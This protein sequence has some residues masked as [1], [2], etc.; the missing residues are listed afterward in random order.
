M[1]L[2]FKIFIA[3]I[4]KYPL[5][6]IL[7]SLAMIAASC[8]V[9]WV[10]SGYDAMMSQFDELP[11]KPL[12]IYDL[13]VFP[14]RGSVPDFFIRKLKAD[15]AVKAVDTFLQVRVNIVKDSG[16]NK[17]NEN[18]GN[19]FA[20]K[21]PL[22]H[23][24]PPLGPTLVGTTAL[25]G[26]Y[27][28]MEGRWIR[29]DALVSEGVLTDSARGR[30]LKVDVG[31][32]VA[33]IS[34]AG[35]FRVKIVGI[36]TTPPSIPRP[37]PDI[38]AGKG[39][40]PK[41]GTQGPD[42]GSNKGY[43][44]RTGGGGPPGRSGVPVNALY[45]S[46]NLAEKVN[47][48][49]MGVSY[50]A[51]KLAEDLKPGVFI[52]NWPDKRTEGCMFVDADT[53]KAA[54]AKRQIGRMAAGAR[55]QAY[56]ATGLS[57]LAAFFIIVTTLSMGVNERIRQ[58]AILR[59]VALSRTQIFMIIAFESLFLALVGWIGGL[60]VGWVI[61]KIG[62]IGQPGMMI[63]GTSGVSI[64]IRCVMLTAGCSFFS[65]FLAVLYPAWKAGK[66]NL[67][68]AMQPIRSS[69]KN[70]LSMIAVII[71]FILISVNYM[72]LNC[73]DLPDKTRLI[74][75]GFIGCPAM[76]VGFLCLTP[77][78]IFVSEKCFGGLL[79]VL[80]GINPKLLK[81][82]LTGNMWRTLGTTVSMTVG[83]GLFCAIH[84]WGASM[85]VPFFPGEWP[86]DMLV[87]FLPAGIKTD[88]LAKYRQVDGV[89]KNQCLPIA[90]EQVKLEG[91]I[92]KSSERRSVVSQDNVVFIG[93]DPDKAFA[94]ASPI[95]KLKSQN[96]DMS[97]TVKKLKN[98]RY[99]IVPDFFLKQSGLKIGDSFK[100]LPPVG[101]RKSISYTIADSVYLPG[102]HWITKMTGL[103]RNSTRT[104]AMIFT[105]YANARR[106]F[107]LDRVHF[108]WANT[109]KGAD[110]M[111]IQAEMQKIAD[112]EGEIS[113]SIPAIGKVTTN[114]QFVN[115]TSIDAIRNSIKNR[116]EGMLWMMTR[117]PLMILLISSFGV[118]NTV[119]ASVNSRKWEMG[120]MRATGTTGFGL[121]KIVF[122]EALL[123]GLTACFI[124]LSF[125][126]TAGFFGTG[127][128]EYS[129]FF[130]GM[131]T[132]LV[133]PWNVLLKGFGIAMLIC[134]SAA[135]WPAFRI[136]RYE[137]LK[138][139]EDGR[140]NM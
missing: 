84:I 109:V 139:L 72:F 49:P 79:A 112:S 43:K 113:Y 96:G 65:A 136:A 93:L 95:L 105:S 50:V 10:V 137:V 129:G 121:A 88:D 87:S 132:P 26:Q 16:K 83:L 28:L 9:V 21:I 120:I 140:G 101:S 56:S 1:S 33:I 35:E 41:R 106:D 6:I 130:G 13:L 74:L 94:G 99:C 98:G 102:L 73:F 89:D 60:L 31:D 70:K 39:G 91:D 110:Y 32:Y 62:L 97:A 2:A 82:L 104:G 81:N 57:L 12:G 66:I 103:R 114:K 53:I 119:I 78:A 7:T 76:C 55:R 117:I 122:A 115:V 75:Y 48:V 138:L 17:N 77:L 90:V 123:I 4:K 27:P 20:Q 131:E 125:G 68:D 47:G 64:G 38:K 14:A 61:I 42:A 44:G 8:V 24:R 34:N 85:L 59:A 23:G 124:S 127:I 25:E 11:E 116:A 52:K 86:P 118:A 128:A 80:M 15:K 111:K 108:L 71:G 63:R 37:V 46:Y 54:K 100:I 51:I 126:I 30:M 92:L 5:R 107:N 69:S 18:G 36:A 22:V 3:N 135:L 134:F 40:G 133:I 29:N 58:F 45:V 19:L 67:L